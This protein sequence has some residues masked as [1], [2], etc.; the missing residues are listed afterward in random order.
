MSIT[1]ANLTFRR[2]KTKELYQFFSYLNETGAE[3]FAAMGVSLNSLKKLF[4]INRLLFGIP[5]KFLLKTMKIYVLEKDKEIIAGYSLTY[6]KIK[7][8]Y[9]LGNF[10]TRLDLQ[11]QGIG[12]LLLSRLI[13]EHPDS[14]IKLEVNVN[15]PIAIHLYEKYG[16]E[17]VNK[18]QLY[19]SEVPLSTKSLPKSYTIRIAHKSDLD[20]LGNLIRSFPEVGDI[21]NNLKNSLDK[22][23]RSFMRFQY[24]LAA[25]IEMNNEIVGVGR[26]I[27]TKTTLRNAD[28]VARA[29]LKKDK[30]V[31]PCLISF[32]T[33]KIKEFGVEKFAW[34]KNE[35]TEEYLTEIEPYLGKPSQEGYL[36]KRYG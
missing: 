30:E 27:W 7:N 9:L 32:I 3:E 21:K 2:I 11:G 17:K 13:S 12:N 8:D 6:N 25:V 34:E 33:Q 22:S 15:N 19:I 29:V 28:I 31:Y 18:V 16:F 4:R 35:Y 20:K 10:F 14:T 5:G 1:E 24:K 36:M 26:A 23:K